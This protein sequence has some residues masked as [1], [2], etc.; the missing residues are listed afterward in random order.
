MIMMLI[1]TAIRKVLCETQQHRCSELLMAGTNRNAAEISSE[2]YIGNVRQNTDTMCKNR[3]RATTMKQGDQKETGR[4]QRNR[5]TTN[6]E[7][8]PEH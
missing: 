8:S 4:P 2:Q 5:A 3:N 1:N 7:R 6:R